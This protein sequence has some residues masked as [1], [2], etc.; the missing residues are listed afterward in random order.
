MIF[1][2]TDIF[3]RIGIM[4]TGSLGTILGAYIARAGLN[5]W[6]IDAD[7]AHVEALNT[8]GA[9]VTG[10]ADFTVP[11]RAVLPEDM[12]GTYDLFIFMAKQTFNETAIPQMISHCGPET[13]ICCCQNGVPESAVAK[14]YSPGK[15]YGAPV[16][17][18]ATFKG[19]GES[20]LT[21]PENACS[22]H[23]G[24]LEPDKCSESAADDIKSVLECMCEVIPTDNLLGDRWTKVSINASLSGMSAVMGTTFGE[25]LDDETG[26]ACVAMIQNEVYKVTSAQGIRLGEFNGYDYGKIP[27]FSDAAGMKACEAELVENNRP[28]RA[29]VAS[30]LQDIRRGRKCEIMQIDGIVSDLGREHGIST[31]FTDTVVRIVK[32]IENGNRVCCRENLTEFKGLLDE[33]NL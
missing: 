12:T 4:G 22:F 20:E 2:G 27:A 11:V 29:L 6:L 31:P 28:Q 18:G 19:P 10:Q 7:T 32:D 23:L 30:M 9:H 24:A 26:L 14:Y 1:G 13:V 25:V 16:G 17:W 15:I 8:H 3:K 21:T 33:V 5:V